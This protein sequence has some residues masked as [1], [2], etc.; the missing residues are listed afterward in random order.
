MSPSLTANGTTGYYDHQT[1][2]LTL[3]G[4]VTP[5]T[6]YIAGIADYTNAIAESNEANNNHNVTQIIVTSP[7]P[8]V[9][10]TTNTPIAGV[11]P[12]FGGG[13]SV[14]SFTLGQ[15]NDAFV[16]KP[17][18]GTE[19]IGNATSAVTIELDGFSSVADNN[20]LE[21][22]LHDAQTGHSQSLFQM[23]NGHDTVIDLGNHDSITLTNVQVADLH[24]SNFIIH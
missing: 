10:A 4:D 3:P 19:V 13:G 18:M 15:G 2:S 5:G 7:T 14:G 16:F 12:A 24:P 1:I 17:G 11:L 6:Y 22:L 8:P 21:T 23:A 9:V 20:Q